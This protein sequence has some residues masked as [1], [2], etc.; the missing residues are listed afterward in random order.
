[1]P[2]SSSP[3]SSAQAARQALA[4]RLRELRLEAG[5]SG[6]ELSRAAGWH[7]AKTSRIEHAVQPV[8]QEDIRT[9]CQVCGV[10]GQAR[11]LVA[12]LRVA[13]GA[14]VEWKRLQR[15][16]QR[17]L[18]Q[19][20]VP[21]YER[22]RRFRSYQ[23]HV[24][25]GLLQTG[26]YASALLKAIAT[27]SAIHNDAEEAAAARLDRQRVLHSD[28][29]FAFVI[30]EAVL[31]YGLGGK[32]VMAKQLGH[33]LEATSLPSVSLGVIPASVRD[34][35]MWTLEGFILFDDA[36]AHVE[37]LTARVTITAPGELEGYEK[38]FQ[39]L[40]GMA[41]YGARARALITSAIEAL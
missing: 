38:A 27:H 17:R 37:L 22:T 20:Y 18:Q 15:A 3:S 19:N 5:L 2:S 6:R 30:E 7:P 28:R 11:D 1:M 14:Y 16:G 25:P 26:G 39:A 31:S 23:S 33:L 4:A 35:P 8:S 36:R 29:R 41:V 34:R 9:W 10:A 12:T 32:E 13:E 21:L 40:S 24:I